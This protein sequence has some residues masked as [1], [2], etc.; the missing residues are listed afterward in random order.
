M[1][2]TKGR[3]L[4]GL[5]PRNDDRGRRKAAQHLREHRRRWTFPWRFEWKASARW[6]GRPHFW[7]HH[8]PAVPTTSRLRQILVS[9]FWER[10]WISHVQKI[11]CIY[12]KIY[13]WQVWDWGPG[14]GIL[15]RPTTRVAQIQPF[16][17]AL[18]QHGCTHWHSAERP[19]SA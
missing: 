1:R 7:L 6:S 4:G 9:F 13:L 14:W 5:L 11:N 19:R 17:G 12:S 15:A 3:C 8:G 16:Q 2:T 10:N 18:Q